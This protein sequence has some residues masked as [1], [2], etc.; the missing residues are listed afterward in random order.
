MKTKKDD[1][2]KDFVFDQLGPLDGLTCRAML[3][4]HGLYCRGAFFGILF[5]NRLY[6]KT[7]A[8]TAAKYA[9]LGMNP[10]Q[11]SAT[12]RLKNYYEVPGDTIEDAAMLCEWALESI[13]VAAQKARGR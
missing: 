7:S 13:A 11:P 3:G 8:T 9:A 12:Q 5:K 6:F 2:F 4:G 1:T 10:F